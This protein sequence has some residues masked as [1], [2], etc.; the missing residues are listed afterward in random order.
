MG[1]QALNWKKDICSENLFG[2]ILKDLPNK[3]PWE[4]HQVTTE[5]SYILS[6]FRIQAK[7]TNITPGKKVVFL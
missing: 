6:L 3:Y 1:P 2:D 5:D 7:G 4:V